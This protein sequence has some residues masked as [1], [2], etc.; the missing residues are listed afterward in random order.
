MV[1]NTPKTSD[2]RAVRKSLPRRIVNKSA[3]IIRLFFGVVNVPSTAK[4]L[5]DFSR[6]TYQIDGKNKKCFT[7]VNNINNLTNGNS[8]LVPEVFNKRMNS[9]LTT[10]ERALV[11]QK[12]Q[13]TS[14][15]RAKNALIQSEVLSGLEAVQSDASSG[16]I[17]HKK[18]GTRH[19]LKQ[20][21][22]LVDNCHSGASILILNVTSNQGILLASALERFEGCLVDCL[23]LKPELGQCGITLPFP[24]NPRQL[25]MFIDWAYDKYEIVHTVGFSSEAKFLLLYDVLTEKF[26]NRHLIHCL[27]PD[28]HIAYLHYMADRKAQKKPSGA[29]EKIDHKLLLSCINHADNTPYD[30]D[31]IPLIPNSMPVGKLGSFAVNN[32]LK[33]LIIAETELCMKIGKALAHEEMENFKLI[34]LNNFLVDGYMADF[35]TNINC[36]ID[37]ADIVLDYSQSHEYGNHGLNAMLAG[38][39]VICSGEDTGDPIIK[40]SVEYLV[41]VVRSMLGEPQSLER[42]RFDILEY[43][44][45]RHNPETTVKKLRLIYNSID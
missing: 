38:K 22:D 2:M 35:D 23:V 26:G 37:K 21:L 9:Y 12:K 28:E 4:L 42:L 3:R 27:N 41:N 1:S 34:V 5:E 19:N 40:S 8:G 43:A 30:E 10:M 25:Y 32:V 11:A 16:Q 6:I 24:E 18:M 7:Q 39:I 44:I 31:L 45:A 14:L 13:I 15:E 29:D 20:T 33:V 17:L 36:L